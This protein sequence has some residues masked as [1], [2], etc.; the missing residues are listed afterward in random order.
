MA[1]SQKFSGTQACTLDTEHTLAETGGTNDLTAT[2]LYV[3]VLDLD[4]LANGDTLILREYVK[5]TGT[6]DTA[7]LVNEYP[8]SN[9]QGSGAFRSLPFECV[10]YSKVTI[11]QTDGTG[12]SVPWSIRQLD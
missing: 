7:R 9:D 3:V 6:G 8:I 12:R 4:V 10:H 1:I 5:T 2:R 11:E